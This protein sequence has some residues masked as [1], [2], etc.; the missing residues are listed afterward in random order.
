MPK[1]LKNHKM[2][3]NVRDGFESL[4][5]M[6]VR[7]RDGYM[8]VLRDKGWTLQSI[9]DAVGD[10]SRE[11]VRQI[12]VSVDPSEAE[13]R[14]KFLRASKEM[15][16]PTPEIPEREEPEK[17][18]RHSPLPS[19]ET[20]DRLR[21]LKPIASKVRYRHSKYR[22]EAEE[23][24][25]LLWHAHSVEGV[26]VYRLAKLLD[27]VPAGIESRLVR[28]GYKSTNGVSVNYTPVKYRKSV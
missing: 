28:Y 22:D 9:A 8:R 26:S 18:D 2:P 25:S 4:I 23:Y 6:P 14:V 19:Q 15:E 21:E 12:I 3:Q 7:Y 17:S 16:L 20:L 10:I 11:R 13:A 24:V 1:V 27:I 5:G